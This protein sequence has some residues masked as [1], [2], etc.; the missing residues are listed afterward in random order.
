MHNKCEMSWNSV[1]R[2]FQEMYLRHMIRSMLKQLQLGERDQTLLSFVDKAMKVEERK[3]LLES[4]YSQ[5]LSLLYILQEDYDRA[6]YYTHNAMQLFIEVCPRVSFLTLCV[7]QVKARSL[8]TRSMS[9]APLELLQRGY[10]V[11]SE[12]TDHPAVSAGL[13][14]NPRLPAVH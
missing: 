8:I 11:D 7:F 1:P 14:R 13:D 4:H 10:A 5:E 6:T 12:S 2:L 3:K 9:L